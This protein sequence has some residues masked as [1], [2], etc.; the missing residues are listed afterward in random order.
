M[1]VYMEHVIDELVRAWG[2]GVW[3]YDRAMKKN[4]KMHVWCQY[5]MYDYPTYGIFY[6]WCVHVM[7]QC[8]VCKEY[9]RFICLKKGENIHRLIS[10][11]N[12]SLLTMHSN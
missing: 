7:F 12:F 3:T 8:T 1:G 9:I 4:F 2:E 10:I 11:E 6:A 5:S